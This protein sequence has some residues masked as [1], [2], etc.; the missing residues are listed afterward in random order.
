MGGPC[1]ECCRRIRS[2]RMRESPGR[3]ES[4]RPGGRGDDFTRRSGMSGKRIVIGVL[5]AAGLGY[6]SMKGYF[7]PKNGH[8]GTI[9]G[10]KRYQAQQI[11]DKD[12]VTQDP[13]M[14]ELV[15]SS[16]FHG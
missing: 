16:L 14:A 10:A 11:T 1:G 15:G 9:G 8:E 3:V 5:A 4:T 12:V 13:Q 6:A 7:P 2:R